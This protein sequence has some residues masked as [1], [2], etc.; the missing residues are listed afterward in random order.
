MYNSEF[1][2][3]VINDKEA[4]HGDRADVLAV[5]GLFHYVLKF[6]DKVGLLQVY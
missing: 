5:T 2:L 4:P 6:T 1:I 3:A